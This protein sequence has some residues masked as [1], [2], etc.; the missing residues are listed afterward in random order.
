ML[1]EPFL[2]DAITTGLYWRVSD[3]VRESDPEAWR[4]WSVVYAE[5]VEALAEELVQALAPMLLDGSSLLDANLHG[6]STVGPI[7]VVPGKKLTGAEL[8]SAELTSVKLTGTEW[9]GLGTVPQTLVK[10]TLAPGSKVVMDYYER[11][12]LVP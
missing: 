3:Y 10:T 8:T 11:A 1:D 9:P 2:L 7:V 4:P 12:G 5:M 6:A